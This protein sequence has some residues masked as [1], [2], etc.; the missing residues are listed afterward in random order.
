MLFLVTGHARYNGKVIIREFT[1]FREF[2]ISPIH[3]TCI[4]IIYY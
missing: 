2:M 3:Y 4:H 1:P